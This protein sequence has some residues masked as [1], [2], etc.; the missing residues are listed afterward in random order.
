MAFQLAPEVILYDH[1]SSHVSRMLYKEGDVL[2]S[3]EYLRIGD[4]IRFTGYFEPLPES[5]KIFTLSEKTIDRFALAGLEIHRQVND[6]YT[7]ELVRTPF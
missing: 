4:V 3:G 2:N 5:C 7:V 6:E 1:D